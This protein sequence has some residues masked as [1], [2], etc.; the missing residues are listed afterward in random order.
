MPRQAHSCSKHCF[1]LLFISLC[2]AC[3]FPER[4][5]V[6]P[7]V[8]PI[9][10]L[11]REVLCSSISWPGPGLLPARYQVRP[12]MKGVG[13]YIRDPHSLVST[14]HAPGGSQNHIY[15]QK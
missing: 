7:S 8:S 3:F 2:L 11:S 14:E 1:L 5:E 9:P 12:E 6:V 15:K 13:L 4:S 10:G